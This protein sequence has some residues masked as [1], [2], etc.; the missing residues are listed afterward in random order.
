[1]ANSSATNQLSDWRVVFRPSPATGAVRTVNCN[2]VQA[3][4]CLVG[5]SSGF[6]KTPTP[7]VRRQIP[8]YLPDNTRIFSTNIN[9]D[10][11]TPVIGGT[12][13]NADRRTL[14]FNTDGSAKSLNTAGS[15]YTSSAAEPAPTL[16]VGTDDGTPFR[17]VSVLTATS[18]VKNAAS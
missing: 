13:N 10:N 9:P 7:T 5:L 17:R 4:Y 15:G 14:Q 12:E 2:G 18:K 8:R 6:P 3:D 11:I 1:M 16:R